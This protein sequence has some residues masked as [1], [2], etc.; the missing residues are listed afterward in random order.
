MKHIFVLNPVAGEHA[1]ETQLLPAIKRAVAEQNLDAVIYLTKGKGDAQSYARMTCE[2]LRATGYT[3][4]V[5]FYAGGGDGTLGEVA[6]GV[7]GEENVSVACLP[8][9]TGNDFVRFF[10]NPVDFRDLNAQISGAT[11]RIDLLKVNGKVCVNACNMGFDALVAHN[12]TVMK[13]KLKL[14]GH[15]A[16]YVSVLYCLFKKL[17]NRF[18]IA[19]DGG[20]AASGTFL[21]AAACN[22]VCYGGGFKGAPSAR[23]DDGLI[24]LCAVRILPRSRIAKLVNL[25]KNGKHLTEPSLQGKLVYC[26]GRHIVVESDAPFV[27]ARDGETE[28]LT[29]VEIEIL[30]QALDFC[31][32]QQK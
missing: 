29:R 20:E 3:G 28:Y 2:R 6:G 14:K 32:P 23:P 10:G 1:V 5:R 9:G 30:P 24:D 31:L 18:Y 26:K 16:Y 17:G 13:R 15:A 22:G 11:L 19:V 21:L 12:V 7:L 4:E 27:M 8:Y 25:Y